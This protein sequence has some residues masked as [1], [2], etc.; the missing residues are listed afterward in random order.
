MEAVVRR[1]RSLGLEAWI[2]A[3][4]PD[5]WHVDDPRFGDV[6]VRAPIG[7]AIV[8]ATTLIEGF[9]GYSA[10][11][12]EMAALFVAYGRGVRVGAELGV[13]SNLSVAPTVL[14]LLGLPIPEAMKAPPIAALGEGLDLEPPID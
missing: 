7:T 2:R 11:E 4:A 5:G 3:A 10:E 12:P 9:H 1:A 6:V 13:V 8:T 14:R